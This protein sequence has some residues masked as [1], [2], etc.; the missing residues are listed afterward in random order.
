LLAKSAQNAKGLEGK[1]NTIKPVLDLLS[2]LEQ[3]S[4][5]PNIDS[6]TK[7]VIAKLMST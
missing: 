2:S 3:Y 6:K 5:N 4:V 7:E 1:H